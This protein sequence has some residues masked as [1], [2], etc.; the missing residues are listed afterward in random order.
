MIG[1]AADP[2]AVAVE[3]LREPWLV[4][5]QRRNPRCADLI[6]TRIRVPGGQSI[7]DRLS[8]L[9]SLQ[10]IRSKG[11]AKPRSDRY[12]TVTPCGLKGRLW[13][14]RGTPLRAIGEAPVGL[15]ASH[16]IELQSNP[17]SPV[18][19]AEPAS[20]ADSGHKRRQN[21]TLMLPITDEAHPRPPA[22]EKRA[23]R[24]ASRCVH[25]R[26]RVIWNGI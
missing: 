17:Q 7:E 19:L 24:Y 4:S 21:A 8:F 25:S 15:R 1:L 26:P 22:Y 14:G 9:R 6:A 20:R 2:I 23:G 12:Q 13:R 18:K 10:S 11:Q 3:A 16:G 5:V